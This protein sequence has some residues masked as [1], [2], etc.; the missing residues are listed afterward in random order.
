MLVAS[1]AIRRFGTTAIPV[2]AY[3]GV[4]VSI[5]NLKIAHVRMNSPPVNALT[6]S[7]LLGLR[8][9]VKSLPS[10]GVRGIILGTSLN[11]VF[12][13]GLDLN[14]LL[15]KDG[16]TDQEFR[17]NFFEYLGGFQE[18][19]K[20]LVSTDLPT[21]AIVEGNAP[22]GGTVLALAC[23]FRIAPVDTEGIPFVMGLNEAG[24]GMA[25]P[26]WVHELARIALPPR[27]L[28]RALQYGLLYQD[29][30]S[31]LDAGFLDELVPRKALVE[32]AV[33]EIVKIGKIP[34]LARSDAKR[35]GRSK[36]VAAM[37]LAA[38]EHLHTSIA[39]DE[40]QGVVRGIMESLKNKKKKSEEMGLTDRISFLRR[41]R[42]VGV[43]QPSRSTKRL[44]R[45]Q[46]DEFV[47]AA[48]RRL[49]YFQHA[50]RI[51]RRKVS[52]GGGLRSSSSR[53]VLLDDYDAQDAVPFCAFNGGSD[54]WVDIGNKLIGVKILQDYLKTA[55]HENPPRW[56]SVFVNWKRYPDEILCLHYLDYFARGD[57]G[58]FEAAS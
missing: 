45:Y 42:A 49:N 29:P 15:K 24:V 26:V 40:F 53:E 50:Q 11:K 20:T 41:E 25:P 19:V 9:T 36:I 5:D 28:D 16:Q 18:T 38:L 10:Q 32:R 23:D 27:T 35:V 4:T 57:S 51:K 48:K 58:G 54:A 6:K 52:H 3:P 46:L 37:D 12:S 39:G 33:A 30:K 55:S 1:R 31:A 44:S 21:A 17:A 56:T 34:W 14:E 2:E 22:A 43:I 47:L 13:A 7:V 8:E